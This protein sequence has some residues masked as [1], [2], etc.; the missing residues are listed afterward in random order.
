MPA[1]RNDYQRNP[2]KTQ[3]DAAFRA[4]EDALGQDVS[5]ITIDHISELARTLDVST[6]GWNKAVAMMVGSYKDKSLLPRALR[7]F[8]AK[9]NSVKN[10]KKK[11]GTLLVPGVP[12]NTVVGHRYGN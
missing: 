1:G 3:A 6:D 10:A 8:N 7:G 4:M 12:E 11:D 2:P 9:V 5:S